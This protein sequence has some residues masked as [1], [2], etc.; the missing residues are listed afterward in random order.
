MNPSFLNRLEYSPFYLIHSR[1]VTDEPK[2]TSE[3]R[4]PEEELF[5]LPL[6]TSL[7]RDHVIEVSPTRIR[8]RERLRKWS[9]LTCP[10]GSLS[11]YILFSTRRLNH[12]HLRDDVGRLTRSIPLRP[13]VL[14]SSPG[15]T[16]ETPLAPVGPTIRRRDLFLDGG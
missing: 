9:V 7:D 11:T 15:G 3:I 1:E 4:E 8:F 12:F 16:S 5:L 10:E 13:T 2:R 14:H 6:Y